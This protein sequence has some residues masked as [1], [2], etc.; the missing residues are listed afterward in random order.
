MCCQSAEG[1]STVFSSDSYQLFISKA[2]TWSE[3]ILHDLHII[4]P[5]R[6]CILG[7]IVKGRYDTDRES[8]NAFLFSCFLFI[9][10]SIQNMGMDYFFKAMYCARCWGTRIGRIDVVPNLTLNTWWDSPSAEGKGG[11]AQRR[12]VGSWGSF[13]S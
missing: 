7:R 2:Q 1:D 4:M 9:I 5:Y 10:L 3:V 6:E 11:R 13:V 12:E 8:E